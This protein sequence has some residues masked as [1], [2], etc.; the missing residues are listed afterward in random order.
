[1]PVACAT[2]QRVNMSELHK[3]VTEAALK[4]D[5]TYI[6]DRTLQMRPDKATA[7]RQFPD[8]FF[9]TRRQA[10]AKKCHIRGPASCGHWQRATRLCWQKQAELAH[11]RLTVVEHTRLDYWR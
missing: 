1:M 10:V 7:C 6:D 4:A 5:N 9:L 11:I 3:I 2:V 8:R